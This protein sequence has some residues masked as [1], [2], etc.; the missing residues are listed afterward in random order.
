MT[1]F[2]SVRRLLTFAIL[3]SAVNL[4][5]GADTYD[6]VLKGGRVIDPETGM[7]AIRNVGINGDK[8]VAISR[9]DLEGRD[10]QDV[11]GLAVVP[12]FI[13]LHAHGQHPV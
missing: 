4:Q 7:D 8:I 2:Q 12:G 13:D 11:S 6:I 9:D 5:A 3:A 1:S 10:V